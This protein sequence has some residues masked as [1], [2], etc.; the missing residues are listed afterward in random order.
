TAE[1]AESAE[2]RQ[3]EERNWQEEESGFL[4]PWFFPLCLLSALSADSAVNRKKVRA[5]GPRWGISRW[6]RGSPP[7]FGSILMSSQQS[8]P[9]RVVRYLTELAGRLPGGQATDR[10]LIERFTRDGSEGAFADLLARHGSMVRAVCRRHLRDAQAADDAF[11]A[12]F[13]VLFR[14]A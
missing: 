14:K 9:R 13:L 8:Q 5:P 2:R 4:E 7:R 1:Y 3:R 12:T 11:Q 10:D 6:G